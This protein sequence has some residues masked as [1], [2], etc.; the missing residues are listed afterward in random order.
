MYP[1]KKKISAEAVRRSFSLSAILLVIIFLGIFFAYWKI[2]II[3]NEYYRQQANKNMIKSIDLSAPRGLITDC[4][5][6]ILSD[7]RTNFTLFL[8]RENIRNRKKTLDMACFLSGK[9]PDQIEN[10]IRRYEKYPRFYMIPLK[11]NISFAAVAFIESREDEF[12]EFQIGTQPLR[13]YPNGHRASHVLGYISEISDEMLRQRSYQNYRMGDSIGMNGIEKQY[14][15][16]LKGTKG[17]QT[18][19]KDNLEKMQKIIGEIKPEI[20]DTVVLTIDLKLQQ[21]VEDLLVN[22]R[23]TVGVVDLQTGGILALVSKPDFDPEIF[24]VA[25][26]MDDWLSIVNDPEKPMQNKFVQG[27][28]SPGSVFKIVMALTGLQEKVIDPT[29]R[30]FCH[31]SAT[32]YDRVFHCWNASGHGEVGVYEALEK[33]CNIFFYTL[34]KKLNIGTIAR[35]ASMLG[36][37]AKS[38]VDLP[39]ENEGVVPSEEWKMRT[40]KQKWFPGETISVAIGGGSLSVT[41]IQIL[42]LISTVALRGR[43][44]SFHLL[45]RV[46]RNGKT[47]REFL[48]SFQ[49]VPIAREYFE[50]VIEGLYRVV[51]KEGTA[52]AARVEGLDICGKT[53]TSQIIAKENPRYDVLTQE[54]RFMPN[55][56]IATFAPR[57]NP[58]IAVVVLVE[59]GGDAGRVAAPLVSQIY[60]KYFEN[61]RLF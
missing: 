52:R 1:S 34:G 41:P 42:K 32:F 18:I 20:G 14:E 53:G 3:E 8:I 21:F 2:Q 6:Q 24:S 60:R 44:V 33:S 56:W 22:Q 45:Q 15:E 57:N 4:H 28:Y 12:P 27:L 47:V 30:V 23:G 59:N 40:L 50:T 31:G 36:L 39:N 10:V 49:T 17:T 19:I 48:P 55:S 61:E 35:Y 29:T 38:F 37:G 46:E 16:F 5:G 13:S 51:N 58:R 7:N 43:A 25:M 26:D 11:N 54:K 9:N